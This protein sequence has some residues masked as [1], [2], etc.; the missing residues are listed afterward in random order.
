MVLGGW[1]LNLGSSLG[2][3]DERNGIGLTQNDYEW[4]AGFFFARRKS[5]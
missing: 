4:G 3:S 5:N 2:G 1:S